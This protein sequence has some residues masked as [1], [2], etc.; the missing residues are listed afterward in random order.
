[1]RIDVVPH[2]DR[3]KVPD[4]VEQA[5]LMVYAALFLSIRSNVSAI[6]EGIAYLNVK[7]E[8]GRTG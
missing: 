6:A 8:V 4:E 1:M 2:L 7:F 5:G 3:S